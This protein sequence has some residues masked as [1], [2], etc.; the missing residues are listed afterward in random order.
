MLVCV[1]T[2]DIHSVGFITYNKMMPV[3]QGKSDQPYQ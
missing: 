2:S 1:C 3:Q